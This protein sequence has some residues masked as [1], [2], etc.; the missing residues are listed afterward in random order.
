MVVIVETRKSGARKFEK[1]ETVAF[2]NPSAQRTSAA[3]SGKKFF[4][5]A[6]SGGAKGGVGR[7]RI[8]HNDRVLNVK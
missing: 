6:P 8:V 3:V 5:V 1:G 7:G 4:S 2:R